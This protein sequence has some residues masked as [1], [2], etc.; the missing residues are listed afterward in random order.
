MVHLRSLHAVLLTFLLSHYCAT[1]SAAGAVPDTMA[2]RVIACGSCHGK[3]GQASN[4]GIYPRIAGKPEAY[5]FNQLQNFRDGRRQTPLMTYLLSNLSD[6]YLHEIAAYFSQQHPPFPAPQ[7]QAATVAATTRARDL[8][9][10]GDSKRGL[11]ACSA[12]HG[13]QLTGT[14]PAIPGLL[15][16]PP[17][18]IN[19][20]FGNW[21]NGVRKA[22][23]PDC[24]AQIAARLSLDD[25]NALSRWLAAQP[26]PIN[27]QA[28][29]RDLTTLP[30][31]CG[32]VLP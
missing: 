13:Q 25:I 11:P 32:S 7:P 27:T 30:M 21:K 8:V 2:Q 24:M 1:A 5:L 28:V 20:Q 26:L 14:L 6:D 12:C 10:Q 9:L 16:L 18:Y 23:A 4:D 19:A 29:R 17:D 15:G 22:R 31:S 3:Q